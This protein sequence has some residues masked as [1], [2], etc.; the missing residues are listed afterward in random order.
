MQASL[1]T[2]QAGFDAVFFAR[3]DYQDVRLRQQA[4][5]SELIWGPA[6][7]LAGAE[8]DVFC[9]TFP[10]HYGPPA[11]FNFDWGQDDPVIQVCWHRAAAAL[12]GRLYAQI[13]RAPRLRLRCAAIQP[14]SSGALHS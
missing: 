13:T 14:P 8:L 3:A 11:G 1:L 12:Q 5:Q 2:G 10:N 4:G 7:S 6:R 9:G